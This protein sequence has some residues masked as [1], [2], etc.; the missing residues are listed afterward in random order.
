MALHKAIKF[1]NPTDENFVG[2]W[3]GEP[4]DVP[5][6]SV[7]DVPS[8]IAHHFAKHLANKIL[9]DRFEKICE[10]HI[11]PS[12]E[13]RKRCAKCKERDNKLG[14]LYTCVERADLLKS[15][16]PSENPVET[17]EEPPVQ[18]Q[19]PQAQEPENEE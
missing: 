8:Y 17:Q 11:S 3:D 15:L 16:L 18:E 10:E 6:K 13:D 12:S 4:Y 2:Y 14:S 7:I 5:A 9:Q 19:E 1:Y